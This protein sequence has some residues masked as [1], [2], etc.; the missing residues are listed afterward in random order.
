MTMKSTIG[1]FNII[2]IMRF[3]SIIQVVYFSAAYQTAIV[4]RL[5]SIQEN[6]SQAI[7]T[8]VMFVIIPTGFWEY[9]TE[10]NPWVSVT[11]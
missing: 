2:R 9:L 5:F 10:F 6:I 4:V 1:Y 3:I 8:K 11:N 7:H